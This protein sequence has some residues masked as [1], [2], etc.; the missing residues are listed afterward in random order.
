MVKILMLDL[1]HLAINDL[2]S[3]KNKLTVVFSVRSAPVLAGWKTPNV[4]K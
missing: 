3:D 2:K 4:K 1:L